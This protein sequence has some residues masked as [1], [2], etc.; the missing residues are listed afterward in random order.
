ML[1]EGLHFNVPANDYHRL[2]LPSNSGLSHF[3]KSPAHYLAAKGQKPTPEMIFGTAYHSYVLTPY[4]FSQEIAIWKG[5]TRKGKE[6]DEFEAEQSVLGRDI[7][8]A[9]DLH[10]MMEMKDVLLHHKFAMELLEGSEREVTLIVSLK[11]DTRDILTTFKARIDIWRGRMIADLKTTTDASPEGFARTIFNRGYH[12]QLGLYRRLFEE[13]GYPI[14]EAFLIAQEKTGCYG[15]CVHELP[16]PL[17]DIGWRTNRELA[18]RYVHASRTNSWD[19]YPEHPVVVNT[20]VWALN[21]EY[22]ETVNE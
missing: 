1:D 6:W 10:K 11:L 5:K 4:W 19:A 20:P 7:I 3:L 18:L 8:T 9:A 16:I 17:L 15:V 14:H 21:N 2:D 22:G 12:R 13:L